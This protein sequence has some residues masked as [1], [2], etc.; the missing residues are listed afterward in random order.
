[1]PQFT[2]QTECHNT[3]DSSAG[4]WQLDG[5]PS[6]CSYQGAHANESSSIRTV[7][8]ERNSEGLAC[9]LKRV[10]YART[11]TES[12][13]QAVISTAGPSRR[14]TREPQSRGGGC[15]RRMRGSPAR[16]WPAQR[17]R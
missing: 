3:I 12:G 1:T 8:D 16:G 2:E 9:P 15:V 5:S 10:G 7:A 13:R 6:L 11:V 17:E 4:R 14:R